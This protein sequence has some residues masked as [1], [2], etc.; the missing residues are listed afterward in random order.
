MKPSCIYAT[1]VALSMIVFGVALADILSFNDK[2]KMVGPAGDIWLTGVEKTGAATGLRFGSAVGLSSA[3]DLVRAASYSNQAAW[4]DNNT[5]L[6][7]G[8]VFK[9]N[10]TAMVH[11]S[12]G[13]VVRV[14]QAVA[15]GFVIDM[16]V[17]ANRDGIVDASDEPWKNTWTQGAGS[18]G[19][20]V[21]VNCDKDD[22]LDSFPDN[23]TGGY[24]PFGYNPGAPSTVVEPDPDY[25]DI[26][27]LYVSKLGSAVLPDN[28]TLTLQVSKPTDEPVDGY[29]STVNPESRVRIFLPSRVNGND[30]EIKAGDVEI[31]GPENGPLASFVK[32]PSGPNQY[33]YSPFA[34]SG[35]IKFGVEGIEFGA[36]VQVTLT[37]KDGANILGTDQV[38]I[39]V[40]PFVLMDHAQ[41]VDVSVPNVAKV[42]VPNAGSANK[43][44]I[45]D[46]VNTYHGN[47][48]QDFPAKWPQDYCEIGYQKAPY[49]SMPVALIFVRDA[50]VVDGYLGKKFLSPTLGIS[51]KVYNNSSFG[52]GCGGNV[53]VVPSKNPSRLDQFFHG[54][55]MS[56]P[57]VDFF[58]AQGVNQSVTTNTSW[59]M[60][61]HV[62]E[63]VSVAPDQQ[64]IIIGDPEVCWGLLLWANSIDPNALLGNTP[65]SQTV[66]SPE[67]RDFNLITLPDQNHLGG[68]RTTLGLVSPES[69]PVAAPGNTGS[70]SLLKGRAFVAFFPSQTKRY[71]RVTFTNAIHYTLEY[72]DEGG[73]WTSVGPG[74]TSTDCVFPNALCFIYSHWWTGTPIAGDQFTF[75]ADPT[76]KTRG[77]PVIWGNSGGAINTNHINCLVDG[78]ANGNTVFAGKTWGPSVI[79][80]GSA[81]SD[82]LNDYVR[83]VFASAGY[84]WIYLVDDTYYSG[85]SLHCGSNVSRAIPSYN[86]WNYDPIP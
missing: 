1:V 19:A 47:V 64:N 51:L 69:Q 85:G 10:G 28:L 67:Y 41:P 4:L 36:H 80:K 84:T 31:I 68:T 40:A 20:I 50:G 79:Y 14:R 24:L 44:F 3:G 76:C 33:S 15:S 12:T 49:G 34:G 65:V 55:G 23:W 73:T 18:H 74:T 37:V 35:T 29:F 46:L 8:L 60:V 16:D 27:P 39:R 62:D 32:T 2:M 48:A 83:N 53:E 17:D 63:I 75:D 25:K 38:R 82:I 13:G 7:G 45:D 26:G 70:G 6:S 9:E 61:G 59:L 71:Y 57:M 77:M 11:M 66:G 52:Q 21:L 81:P 5:N 72:K 78:N 22:P 42:W 86:W 58:N 54:D 30:R 43:D 56:G